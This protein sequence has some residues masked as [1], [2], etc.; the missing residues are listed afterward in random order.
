[1]LT[2][3]KALTAFYHTATD[4]QKAQLIPIIQR[5][6]VMHN[7]QVQSQQFQWLNLPPDTGR[8]LHREID[9]YPKCAN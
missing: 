5:G 8:P 6:L 1:M 2:L 9:R 4:E 7:R 3:L